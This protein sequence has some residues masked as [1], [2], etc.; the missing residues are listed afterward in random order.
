MIKER[1]MLSER[2]LA[3]QCRSL[4]KVII[5]EGREKKGHILANRSGAFF[6][7]VI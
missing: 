4:T 3:F 7:A 1:Y 5:T 6:I 2:K